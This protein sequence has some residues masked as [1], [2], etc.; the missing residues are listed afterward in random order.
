[1]TEATLQLAARYYRALP[2]DRPRYEQV[3]LS[4]PVSKTALSW[5]CTAG[6]HRLPPDECGRGCAIC[7]TAAGAVG[8]HSWTHE[9]IAPEMV[10]QEIGHTTPLTGFYTLP[11]RTCANHPP[12]TIKK[13]RRAWRDG[14]KHHSTR[15]HPRRTQQESSAMQMNPHLR[16]SCAHL[17]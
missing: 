4:L 2:I 11:L 17:R 1:M 9:V 3:T 16:K 5:A 7:W 12:Y 14:H 15:V 13:T 10:D 6:T 8:N